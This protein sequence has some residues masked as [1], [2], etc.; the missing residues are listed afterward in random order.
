MLEPT[1][2]CN[3]N[4]QGCGKIAFS[5]EVLDRRLS[6]D[7]CVAAAEECGAPVVSIPGGEPLLHPDIDRIVA[8]L[9]ARRR[10]VYLCTNALLL[11]QRLADF[12]P[13]PYLIFNIHLD[14]MRQHHDAMVL[15]PGVFDQAVAAIGL[16]RAGGFRVTTNT[17][18]FAGE[19]AAQAGAFFDF[20]MAQ[21]VEGITVS[22]GFGYA[23]A[24]STDLFLRRQ[25]TARLFQRAVRP[26]PGPLA[27]QPQQPLSRFSRRRPL[28]SLFALG[29]PDAQCLRLAKAV[30]PPRRRLC[31][32]L[33]R[34]SGRNGLVAL[35]RRPRQ[36]LRRL[37]GALRFRGDGGARNGTSS[38]AGVDGFA[39]SRRTRCRGCRLSKSLLKTLHHENFLILLS[40]T[41]PVPM[42]ATAAR[43]RPLGP[44][45]RITANPAADRTLRTRRPAAPDG[46]ARARRKA[47]GGRR[48]P[49]AE[50]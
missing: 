30:L 13:S 2:R 34:T 23:N 5:E 8:E 45:R 22:P 11:R 27:V 1:F 20:L 43:K 26:R 31:R 12:T 15:R 41:P 28:L 48:F 19:T 35:R 6:V 7:E 38:A 4:C 25:E 14:G 21:G 17:T 10:F 3:L 39:P 33:C 36:P 32:Y 40:C 50:H 44:D 9:T 46:P 37:H 16:L 18:L 24:A 29:K 47:P 49:C 42:P